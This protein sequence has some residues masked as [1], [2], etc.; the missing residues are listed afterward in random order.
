MK[1]EESLPLIAGGGGSPPSSALEILC[2]APKLLGKA[3]KLL[4]PVLLIYLIPSSLLLFGTYIAVLPLI[5]DMV[6]KFLAV[7]TDD[8]SFSDMVDALLPKL[9]EDLRGLAA[10]EVVIMLM[11]FLFSSFLLTGVINALAMV[12]KAD[13]VTFKDLFYKIM[14]TWK[15]LVPT[16]VYVNLLA[17]AYLTIWLLLLGVVFFVF[18]LSLSS[19]AL[20]TVISVSG[21]LLLLYLN[22]V[23]SQGVVV[24][25]TEEGRYGLT[26]LGR[27]AEL[28]QG[29][30]RLA[31]RVNCLKFLIVQGGNLAISLLPLEGM[32]GLII[33][34]ARF[35]PLV[36]LSVFCVAVDVAFY[37]EHRNATGKGS[38]EELGETTKDVKLNNV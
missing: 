25:A 34:F 24:S 35:L 18:D 13:K 3:W 16:L 2:G 22:M 19:I 6:E 28:V 36:F 14:R 15:G 31:L 21:I 37:N 1:E 5:S 33:M 9:T 11:S 26:A 12:A 17:F 23:W 20:C 38:C 27:A 32:N 7:K 30:R 8:P 29:R 10:T 4:I